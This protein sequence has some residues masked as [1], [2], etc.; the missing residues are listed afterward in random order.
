MRTAFVFTAFMISASGFAAGSRVMVGTAAS[1]LDALVSE[2]TA[3]TRT[4]SLPTGSVGPIRLHAEDFHFVD[5]VLSLAGRAAEMENSDFILKGNAA[6]VYGWIVLRDS[7][8]AYE[9]TTDPTGA[10]LVEE[11]PIEK[12]YP[13]CDDPSHAPDP[14]EEAV[15]HGVASSFSGLAGPEPHI[16][17]YAGQDLYKLQSLPGARKVLWLDISRVM[18][19]ATPLH[20]SK[21]E[22]YKMWQ[23]HASAFSMFAV[24]VTTDR[25]VYN[26]AGVTNSGINRFVNVSGRS[27]CPVNA[28][29]TTRYCQTQLQRRPMTHYQYG[30]TAVHETGH[31]MG[32]RH[33]GNASTSYF[34]GFSNH[35]WSPI[36]G[37]N[38]CCRTWN[39]PAIQW[40][41]GEYTGA[42]NK[43]DDLSIIAR[44]LPFKANP[45]KAPVPL[46]VEKDSVSPLLNRGLIRSEDDRNQFTFEVG[47][48][49][50][51]L[52]LLVDRTEIRGGSALDID[53]RILDSGGK[54]LVQSNDQG[55]RSARFSNVALSPGRYTLV[56]AG[57]E[58]GTPL[59]G[60]SNY[61]SMGYYAIGGRITG[62]TPTP[63][64]FPTSVTER[65][66]A[67]PRQISPRFRNGRLHLDLPSGA[68]VG[69]V[70]LHSAGGAV[71]HRSAGRVEAIDFER[72]PAGVYLLSVALDDAVVRLKVV[73]E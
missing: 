73:K 17:P 5:G 53:A 25:D 26:S 42:N 68:K 59:R 14:M 28:F 24:N 36:M 71:V 61:A 48:A 44:N 32:L 37:N 41:K 11:V 58:E 16:G 4:L 29:G 40:S 39:E 6:G 31:L 22:M 52:N 47:P 62:V 46:R 35:Q 63:S 38:L 51:R 13:V 67:A 50:G 43:Q 9:Y 55:V 27:F 20:M 45:I 33:D 66:G 72:M 1:F 34:S 2:N 18:D 19:G 15:T 12:I 49:G 56:I 7:K 21:E 57:G 64:P 3:A 65:A 69:S 70:V 23:I 30:K 10:L 8:T 54:I 60:F